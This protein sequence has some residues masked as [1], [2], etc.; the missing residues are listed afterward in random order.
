MHYNEDI[1]LSALC[2]RFSYSKNYIILLFKERYGVTPFA[3][4]L[5]LRLENAKKLLLT[6]SQSAESVA[7]D[8]GFSDYSHFY[9][10]FKKDTGLSPI[11]W[12]KMH[13][14]G[15]ESEGL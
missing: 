6:S 4:L 10:A 1:S 9:K 14:V 8:S 15:S 7:F 2:S 3:Y 12:K 5:S 11:H 13:G